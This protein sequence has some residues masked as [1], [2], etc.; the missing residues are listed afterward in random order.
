M[1]G[2]WCWCEGAGGC[3]GEEGL[4]LLGEDEEEDP[5]LGLEGE[6]ELL[7]ALAGAEADLCG[8]CHAGGLAVR[9]VAVRGVRRGGAAAMH[10]Q[11]R[12]AGGH[13]P[14]GH[15]GGRGRLRGGERGGGRIRR[16][17]SS[18]TVDSEMK[19]QTTRAS[20]I[21]PRRPMSPALFS[22]D[23]FF[24]RECRSDSKYKMHISNSAIIRVSLSWPA[25]MLRPNQ[26]AADRVSDNYICVAVHDVSE[27]AAIACER[28]DAFSRGGG[29]S[30]F[31]SLLANATLGRLYFNI[32]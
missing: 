22:H 12:A 23:S 32:N 9:G 31:V 6:L 10:R 4:E 13:V 17:R 2:L 8:E 28:S 14:I 19:K 16:H 25:A 30:L 1:G 5:V 20:Q 11:R 26:Y 3:A 21:S 24:G 15:R 7:L 18:G 29:D 27:D